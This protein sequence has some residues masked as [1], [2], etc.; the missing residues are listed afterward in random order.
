VGQRARCLIREDRAVSVRRATDRQTNLISSANVS[1]R[2]TWPWKALGA[3]PA[4]KAKKPL[5]RPAKACVQ[6]A[7]MALIG[8]VL[9]F[10]LHRRVMPIVVWSLAAL[11]LLGGFA[12]PP[13][14]DAFEKFGAL[15]A[16]WVSA[17]LTWGLLVPFFYLCFVPARIIVSLSGKDPM[18]RRFPDGKPS[19]WVPR[20]PVP[21]LDQYRKQH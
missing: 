21:N 4:A 1:G 9:F 12:V 5:S 11:V 3:V 10:L 14:F 2:E 18:D 8:L 17:G 19:F 15:L 20:P 16:R 13:L 7:V 6:A